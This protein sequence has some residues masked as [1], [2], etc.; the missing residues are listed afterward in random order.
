MTA[1]PDSGISSLFTARY[2]QNFVCLSALQGEPLPGPNR[3]HDMAQSNGRVEV[4]ARF[5]EAVWL[6]LDSGAFAKRKDS[7]PLRD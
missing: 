7:L 2:N 4:G 5:Q 6:R 1:H 3:D